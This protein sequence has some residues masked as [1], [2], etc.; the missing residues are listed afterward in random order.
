[1]DESMYPGP[2]NQE[3]ISNVGVSLIVF[4]ISRYDEIM[5]TLRNESPLW[6]HVT[7]DPADP[8]KSLGLI[9]TF[10]EPIGDLENENN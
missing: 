10:E 8:N 5:S 6:F 1:M 7:T 2:G 4:P 3:D 9:T